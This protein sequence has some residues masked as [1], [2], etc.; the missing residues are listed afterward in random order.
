V[1]VCPFWGFP[2]SPGSFYVYTQLVDDMSAVM[3]NAGF[4]QF[5]I[6]VCFI[7]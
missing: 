6:D 7:P 5:P 4:F 1:A 3:T 2:F